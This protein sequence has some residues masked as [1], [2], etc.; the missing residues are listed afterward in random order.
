MA[1]ARALRC[2]TVVAFSKYE[3]TGNDFILVRTASREDFTP[4]R[5]RALCDR[6]YGIGGD[7][8]ILVL[9]AVAPAHH[10]RMLILNADGSIPEM[11]GNGIRCVATLVAKGRSGIFTIESDAGPRTCEVVQHGTEVLVTVDMGK[12]VTLGK[13]AVATSAGT[14]SL[15]EA[16]AG[17][18][19][20]ILFGTFARS[21]METLGR[22]V[23]AAY[24]QGTNV[25]FARI[26]GSEVELVVWERG[27]GFTLACGT[28][29]SATARAAW[30]EGL[31]PE[32]PTTVRLPGGPLTIVPLPNHHVSMRGPARHVFDGV[33]VGG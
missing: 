21:E 12:V 30:E 15:I 8:V 31:L 16:T 11:C 5:V 3:G 17:N 7:G 32:G 1:R 28:G 24:P 2:P 26:V 9:P 23:C 19:H 6:H 10:A 27:V 20:A 25:E 22:A 33:A 13:R 18:P 4:E 29:A 14:V